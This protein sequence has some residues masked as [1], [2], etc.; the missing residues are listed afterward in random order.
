MA[1]DPL[2]DKLLSWSPY[3]YTLNNSVNYFDPDGKRPWTKKE[4]AAILEA[5]READVRFW[6][7]QGLGQAADFGVSIAN[8]P[9]IN[10]PIPSEVR[11]AVWLERAKLMFAGDAANTDFINGDAGEYGKLQVNL[12]ENP[13]DIVISQVFHT[14]KSQRVQIKGQSYDAATGQIKY[15]FTS[16]DGVQNVIIR[17][18]TVEQYNRWVKAGEAVALAAQAQAKKNGRGKVDHNKLFKL[19][20]RAFE[21]TGQRVGEMGN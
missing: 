1:V 12:F 10:D 14:F 16:K 4:K 6:T 5:M 13:K 3:N 19:F 7:A 11:G 17:T 2:A 9:S 8:M 20:E 15:Q 21:A 18:V